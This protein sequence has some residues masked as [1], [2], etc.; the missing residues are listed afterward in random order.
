M[1]RCR[2]CRHCVE[3]CAASASPIS[4]GTGNQQGADA[5]ARHIT[6]GARREAYGDEGLS[7]KMEAH[8]AYA[9][10]AL[11]FL[12]DWLRHEPD[13]LLAMARGRHAE[14]HYRFGDGLMYEYSQ[15]ELEAEAAQELADAINYIALRIQR[16]G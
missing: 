14:G 6:A 9:P 3:S 2:G 13:A 15:N 1:T 7:A 11:R 5:E 4:T 16:S 10:A 12:I 8:D